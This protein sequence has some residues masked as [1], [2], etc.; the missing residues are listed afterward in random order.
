M[1]DKVTRRRRSNKKKNRSLIIVGREIKLEENSRSLDIGIAF[2]LIKN[3][4]R[5]DQQS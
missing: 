2:Q 3:F 1:L 5:Q 4:K